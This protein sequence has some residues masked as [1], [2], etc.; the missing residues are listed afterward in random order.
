MGDRA[1]V[2]AIVVVGDPQSPLTWSGTATSLGAALRELGVTV[3]GLDLRLPGAFDRALLVAGAL[4]T[5][6]RYDAQYAS[7][8]AVVRRERAN[9]AL[10]RLRPDGVIQIGTEVAL[11]TP[12]PVVTLEDMTLRQASLVHPVFSR[13]SGGVVASSERRRRGIYGRARRCCFSSEWAARSA[14]ED[15]GL[16]ADE[17][18]VVGVGAN[19][20]V[21]PGPRDWQRPRFLFVGLDWERKGG[22]R[23][24]RA[25]ARLRAERPDATLDVVG[26][27]P[28][29]DA[30][31]VA[32]HGVLSLDRPDQ[33]AE[34]TQLFAS[35][36]CLVMPSSIEPAGIV[37]IEAGAMGVPSIVTAVGGARELIG[38]GG[39]AVVDPGD[40]EAL[41]AAM[42]R[43][44]DAGEARRAGEAAKERAALYTWPL[45][46]QRLLRALGLTAGV[47]AAAPL[48]EF[49]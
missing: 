3:V 1:P 31:G 20:L 41:L 5:R 23:V 40:D 11:A 48:A 38:E 39:G 47:A 4:P 12:A 42:R 22:P 8:V 44:A 49:L 45:V 34:L 13:M 10:P 6:N 25:F 24:L 2:V 26:G 37:Y 19:H 43:L 7:I 35:A 46:A 33:R 18:A 16:A 29:L 30:P 9:R 14:R 21:A 28:P 17:V 15:Y 36:T 27:H 32:A